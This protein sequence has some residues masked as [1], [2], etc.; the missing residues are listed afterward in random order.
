M[1]IQKK[2]E[3]DEASP[4]EPHLAED[5][6]QQAE[7]GDVETGG[8]DDDDDDDERGGMSLAAVVIVLLWAVIGGFVAWLCASI[9][10]LSVHGFPV[11]FIGACGGYVAVSM[12]IAVIAIGWVKSSSGR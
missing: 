4:G 9:W 11:S 12:V 5:A 1:T 2:C 3:N 7:V 10:P 8:F 6:R